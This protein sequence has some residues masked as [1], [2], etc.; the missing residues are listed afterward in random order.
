MINDCI[1]AYRDNVT[2]VIA[3]TE[4]LVR[5]GK[6]TNNLFMLVAINTTFRMVLSGIKDDEAVAFTP[7]MFDAVE[8]LVKQLKIMQGKKRFWDRVMGSVK[9]QKNLFRDIAAGLSAHK[10]MTV[11]EE[12]IVVLFGKLDLYLNEYRKRYNHRFIRCPEKQIS[13]KSKIEISITTPDGRI[14][15]VMENKDL[16]LI[17]F[18][19]TDVGIEKSTKLLCITLDGVSRKVD[20]AEALLETKHI[21]TFVVDAIDKKE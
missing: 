21:L 6:H 17:S 16:I 4:E 13:S 12:E 8:T 20:D 11:T 3:L 19:N 18:G 7:T 5:S 15:K 9:A 1:Q 10:P 2:S 14:W